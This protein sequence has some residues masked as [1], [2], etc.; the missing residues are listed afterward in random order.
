MIVLWIVTVLVL[1]PMAVLVAECLAALWPSR[2]PVVDPTS[3]RPSCAVLIPAHNEAA[4]IGTTLQSLLPQLGP[5]DRIL[6][7]AD[8]C[9]DCTATT[10]RSYGVSVVERSHETN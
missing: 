6:V 9:E 3:P 8:N 10:A 2:R 1:I 7:V 4:G 5:P